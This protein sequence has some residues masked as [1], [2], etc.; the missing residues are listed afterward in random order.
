MNAGKFLAISKYE[1]W[2]ER[3]SATCNLNTYYRFCRECERGRVYQQ[4]P[5]AVY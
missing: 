5:H 3:N 1:R 4:K 2:A